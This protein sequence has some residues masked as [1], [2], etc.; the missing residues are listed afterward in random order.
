MVSQKD[1][2]SMVAAEARAHG[3]SYG[4]WVA[5]QWEKEKKRKASMTPL[6]RQLEEAMQIK[7]A[8]EERD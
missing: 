7:A 5:N 3:M 8:G 1:H 2:L 4:N 6:E